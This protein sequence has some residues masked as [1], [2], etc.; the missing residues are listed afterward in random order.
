MIKLETNEHNLKIARGTTKKRVGLDYALEPFEGAAILKP[1]NDF[2]ALSWI[3][4][5]ELF[6]RIRKAIPKQP[7]IRK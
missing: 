5:D 2:E 7:E 1:T 6:E 3:G 4:K